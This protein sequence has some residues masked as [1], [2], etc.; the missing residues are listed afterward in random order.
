MLPIEARLFLE[1]HR[2]QCGRSAEHV[3]GPAGGLSRRLPLDRSTWRAVCWV[4]LCTETAFALRTP[5]A[6]RATWRAGGKS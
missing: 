3:L 6:D 5:T 1:H 2:C 4:C